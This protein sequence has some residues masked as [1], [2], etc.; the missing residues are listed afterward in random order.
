[1]F[2]IITVMVIVFSHVSKP[3]DSWLMVTQEF[4]WLHVH[5]GMAPP[6][7]CSV[8][9]CPSTPSS[10]ILS[11]ARRSTARQLEWRRQGVPGVQ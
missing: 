4:H 6:W 8:L 3:G 1:M 2:M 11:A 7:L 9:P 5:C 10:S